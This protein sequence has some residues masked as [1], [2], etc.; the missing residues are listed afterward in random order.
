MY[1]QGH[2]EIEKKATTFGRAQEEEYLPY[3]CRSCYKIQHHMCRA[4]K[5]GAASSRQ[6]L[7]IIYANAQNS[8]HIDE[9]VI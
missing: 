5:L 8:V 2:L 1:P 3:M 4:D 7:E 6:R 9:I